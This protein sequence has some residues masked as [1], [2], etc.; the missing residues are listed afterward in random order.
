VSAAA[1]SGRPDPILSVLTALGVLAG[2]AALALVPG[3]ATSYVL[4]A[5]ALLVL[6]VNLTTATGWALPDAP[7]RLLNGLL[8]LGVVVVA[9]LRSPWRAVEVADA[10]GVLILFL[11]L[12]TFQRKRPWDDFLLLMG[13]GAA[14]GMASFRVVSPL[15]LPVLLAGTVAVL[16]G[17]FRLMLRSE[18][19]RSGASEDRPIVLAEARSGFRRA[20]EALT[21]TLRIGLGVLAV[22]SVFF[23]LLPRSRAS[24]DLEEPEAFRDPVPSSGSVEE[25]TV[26][27]S[28]TGF[29][30]D[31]RLGD[32]GRIKRDMRIALWMRV[33]RDEQPSRL[34]P[35]EAY[36][37]G[38]AL[39]RFDGRRWTA[40]G[41]TGALVRGETP[42]RASFLQIEPFP[43]AERSAVMRLEQ[44]I[45]QADMP[46][47]TTLFAVWR[48]WLVDPRSTA[49]VD[50]GPGSALSLP[51]DVGP[52]T[53]AYTIQS[54]IPWKGVTDP[55]NE[56]LGTTER[57]RLT[58][59]P[60]GHERVRALARELV[61]DFEGEEAGRLLVE[62]LRMR[63]RYTLDL[64]RLD[65]A[66][67]LI[68]F[69]FGV[70]EGHCE[71]F[72]S[73]LAMLLRAEGIPC[74]LV[75][76]FRG[77]EWSESAR[78]HVVRFSHAHAWVEAFYPGRGWVTLD[79]TPGDE[80]ALAP[81]GPAV[82]GPEAPAAEEVESVPEPL[83]ERILEFDRED[84]ERLWAGIR[85]AAS[86][87]GEGIS[88]VGGLVGWAPLLGGGSFL[89]VGIV[90][91][92]L[93][94]RGVR[95]RGR[96]AGGRPRDPAE[97]AV[98]RAYRSM[99]T[100][101]AGRGVR[102]ER[103]ETP[104]ELARRAGRVLPA[105]A[106]PVRAL[107]DLHEAV[108]YGFRPADREEARRAGAV[109][110]EV[111]AALRRQRDE[112]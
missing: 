60:G 23:V 91:W 1:R 107:T 59:I 99:L 27:E 48:P 24:M 52:G 72:A 102:R 84:Q 46:G 16:A 85:E 42:Q 94:R 38:V 81:R 69:L 47:P 73:A 33:Y 112:G 19:P 68:D 53:R 101:L 98:R 9:V 15:Y 100:R 41:R 39:T 4:A 43:D 92:P 54:L 106:S 17:A 51:G 45:V 76:G 78:M 3:V 105:A 89:L 32:I 20:L 6:G 44:E 95:L 61:G 77:H 108:C 10:A 40:P 2:F 103:G 30:P 67:P 8:L 25:E 29:R 11:V 75:A 13:A 28:R 5:A 56:R 71:L 35:E 79:P 90:A 86:D 55:W 109:L 36:L 58:R 57:D 96:A 93:L 12:R 63:C 14:L 97:D 74:R 22:A 80:S 82:E 70:R 18:R 65:P 34:A 88:S 31:V 49:R 37:R 64:P 66:K 50:V 104:R 83:G 87:L 110:V 111:R 62:H 7:A 26:T 21:L